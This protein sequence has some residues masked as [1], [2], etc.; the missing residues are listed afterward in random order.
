MGHKGLLLGLCSG[1]SPGGALGTNWDARDQTQVGRVQGKCSVHRTI[2][3]AHVIN[4]FRCSFRGQS[5]GLKQSTAKLPQSEAK[6]QDLAKGQRNP[7]RKG[8]RLVLARM[9]IAVENGNAPIGQ[10]R[11]PAFPTP[12]YF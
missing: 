12:G 8:G 5:L 1:I 10:A 4:I 11:E 6:V 9:E 7:K 2:D 3:L